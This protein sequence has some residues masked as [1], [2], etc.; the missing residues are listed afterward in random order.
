MTEVYINRLVREKHLLEQDLRSL[1]RSGNQ[2][3]IQAIQQRISLIDGEIRRQ[4]E[5]RAKRQQQ[6]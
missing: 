2:S 5:I 1:S 6:G 4:G 3:Q